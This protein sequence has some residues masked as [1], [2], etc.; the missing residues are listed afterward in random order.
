M[1]FSSSVRISSASI[2]AAR[3]LVLSIILCLQK[4]E[5]VQSVISSEEL[6][7]MREAVTAIFV[8]EELYKYVGNLVNLTRTHPMVDL[9]ISPRGTMNIL[10]MAKAVAFL[11]QQNCRSAYGQQ[12]P[13]SIQH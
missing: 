6:L 8:Q 5:Q 4:Q 3:A 13:A 10:Q 9:G 7:V 2:C 12:R 1:R 11:R